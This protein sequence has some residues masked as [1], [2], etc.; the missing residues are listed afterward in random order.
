MLDGRVEPGPDERCYAG[1]NL[2]KAVR[3]GDSCH[4][5]NMT[6]AW[7]YIMANRAAGTLYI[8]VTTDLARRCWEHRQGLGSAFTR[9]YRLHRLVFAE[10]HEEVATAI[11]RE[12]S[13]KRWRRDWKLALIRNANPGWRDLYDDLAGGT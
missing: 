7:V 11:Q 2:A 1:L 9:R 12:T 8:G 10:W 3:H 4:Y 13:L 5:R 6:G